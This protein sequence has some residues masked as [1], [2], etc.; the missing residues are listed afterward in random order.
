MIAAAL[1][2]GFCLLASLYIAG[3]R[4]VWYDE[5]YTA[6]LSR[7]Q[8]PGEVLRLLKAGADQQPLL[9]YL[10][11]K[12]SGQLFGW[13]A[14]SLRLP[15]ALGMFAGLLV[16]FDCVRR[17][18]DGL[19]GLLALSLLICTV[20]PLYGFEARPYALVFMWSA[21]SLWL[22]LHTRRD[23]KGAAL[24]FGAAV[25]G[26]VTAHYYAI[27]CL[28]PYVVSALLEIRQKGLPLKIIAGCA[29]AAAGLA[30]MLPVAGALRGL[31]GSFWAPATF[32]RLNEVF[33][34]LFPHFLV[35]LSLIAVWIS[36]TAAHRSK[37][38]PA[39]PMGSSE[40]L[41][42]LF[43][44]IPYAGFVASRLVTH[45]L[46]YRYF[47]GMLPGVAV[48][49]SCLMWRR[50]RHSTI[51]SAGVLCILAGSGTALS[52][53]HL[54]HPEVA[55]PPLASEHI[56][57][58]EKLLQSE[59]RFLQD[60]KQF[61]VLPMEPS[62]LAVEAAYL[63]SRPERYRVLDD[64]SLPVSRLTVQNR[65]MSRY[66]PMHFW[67]LQDLKEHARESVLVGPTDEMV[68]SSEE[69]GLDLQPHPYN[70][71]DVM[72]VK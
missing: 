5:I 36:V 38:A 21:C 66:L 17:L 7:Q 31:T 72:Y 15:S 18:T 70:S 26:S 46:V 23:S 1:L 59:E 42:W 67:N 25:F 48:G 64:P 71:L 55:G 2:A 33:V 56:G 11:V 58:I 54:H 30:L 4:I 41:A 16:T 52:I 65:A 28:I 61:V 6:L 29:G 68:R 22:W 10:L 9:Y 24:A 69:A 63:S 57:W 14:V 27:F 32:G 43:L 40:R 8:W 50:Y 35:Y 39:Q 51:A 34:D 47:I 49:F 62:L 12:A 3:R 60:G 13:N 53:A 45:A 19:R 44:L 20:L 37:E